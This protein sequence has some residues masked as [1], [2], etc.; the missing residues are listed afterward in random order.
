MRRF[1]N[2]AF[3]TVIIAAVALVMLLLS[4]ALGGAR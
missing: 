3:A 1:E 4:G 2:A